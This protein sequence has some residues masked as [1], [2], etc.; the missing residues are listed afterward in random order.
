MICTE[1]AIKL[2]EIQANTEKIDCIE[3][4]NEK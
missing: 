4:G 1:R 2:M 3:D